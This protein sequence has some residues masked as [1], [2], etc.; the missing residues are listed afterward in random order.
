MLPLPLIKMEKKKKKQNK[1]KDTNSRWSM[2][3]QGRYTYDECHNA[4]KHFSL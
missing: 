4:K 1:T 3:T 2:P